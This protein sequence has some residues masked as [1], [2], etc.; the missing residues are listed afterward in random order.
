MGR[1]KEKDTLRPWLKDWARWFMGTA[2]TGYSDSTTLYRAFYARNDSPPGSSIPNGVIPPA[3]IDQIQTAMNVLKEDATR[4]TAIACMQSFYCQGPEKTME[5][6][7][8]RKRAVYALKERGED[9]LRGYLVAVM[10]QD[11]AA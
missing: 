1:M 5:A 7:G 10:R 6:L 3:Y 11:N 9:I 8:L 2:R 4:R